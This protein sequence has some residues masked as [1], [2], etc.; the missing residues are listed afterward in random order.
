MSK[1]R[2]SLYI[3]DLSQC[4]PA[5]AL[6]KAPRRGHWQ[7][8]PYETDEVSGTMLVAGEGCQAP[9]VALPLGVKGWHAVH[10]GVWTHWVDSMI[11]VK[12]TRD[13]CFTPISTSASFQGA[14]TEEAIMGM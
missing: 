8:I 2:P 5:S 10:L 12:L 7:P 1:G 3:A 9:P 11:K 14:T 4:R 13:P 6:S